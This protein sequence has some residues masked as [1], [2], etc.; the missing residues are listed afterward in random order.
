MSCR[1]TGI[2]NWLLYPIFSIFNVVKELEG[3]RTGLGVVSF[4]ILPAAVIG[5]SRTSDGRRELLVPLI[6]AGIFFTIW[7]FSGTT[8]RTRHLLP[9]YPLVLVTAFPAAIR[10]ARQTR[11]LWPA[12][13]GLSAALII[14]LTGHSLFT[15]NYANTFSV[16][17][18]DGSFLS[19]T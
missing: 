2:T 13:A 5:I 19:A 15:V 4:L 17:R 12:S 6:I 3:G 8:Q 7:F 10:W 9:V 14:Q 16:L 18:P 11:L 1:W